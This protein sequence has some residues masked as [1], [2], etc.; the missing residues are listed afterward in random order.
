MSLDQLSDE[1]VLEIAEQIES[2]DNYR[3]NRSLRPLVLCS[4][5]LNSIVSPLLYRTFTQAWHKLAAL[6]NLLHLVMEKPSIRLE[7]KKLVLKEIDDDNVRGEALDMSGYS[8]QDFERCRTT[9]DSFGDLPFDKSEWLAGVEA[10]HWDAVISFLL[11]FLPLLEEID[12]E[13]GGLSNCTYLDPTIRFMAAN[14]SLE[15]STF[16]LKHLKTFS[17]AYWDTEMGMW[18]GV[19]LPFYTLPSITIVRADS[20]EEEDPHPSAQQPPLSIERYQVQ[21][22]RISNSCI[23]GNTMVNLLRCFPSLQK[24]YY[25]HG[26]ATVGMADFLPQKLGAGIAHLHDSLEELTLLGIEQDDMFG[27]DPRRPVGSLA[28]FKKLRCIGTE[29]DVLFE[30]DAAKPQ[31]ATILPSSLE[32]L[33]VR[34]CEDYIYD[35][36]RDLIRVIA[37]GK[38]K[39]AAFKFIAIDIP[40]PRKGVFY[41]IG[42][43][44]KHE[45]E[46]QLKMYLESF[47]LHAYPFPD[48]EKHIQNYTKELERIQASKPSEAQWEEW[49]QRQKIEQLLSDGFKA[50]GIELRFNLIRENAWVAMPPFMFY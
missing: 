15:N 28:A 35:Q 50:A 33:V 25:D 30:P 41:M 48:R 24:L 26:G 17:I 40:N 32:T 16:S 27:N 29:A 36:L 45:R 3:G 14:Q 31:L 18:P 22:L 23:G 7:I 20:L 43:D 8:P 2:N 12:I 10:G 47:V 1:L 13:S 19:I 42:P 4:R 46:E 9:M 21:N 49:R 39:F 6:P 11:F 34:M 37:L 44:G 5:R 38:Q